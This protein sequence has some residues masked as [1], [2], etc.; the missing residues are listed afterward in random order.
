M[1]TIEIKNDEKSASIT[2]S[3]RFDPIS[4]RNESLRTSFEKM[5]HV[6]EDLQK[7]G[8]SNKVWE[9]ERHPPRESSRQKRRI[10]PPKSQ[11]FSAIIGS[12]NYSSKVKF[13]Q[14]QMLLRR[15]KS[16][17]FFHS[18]DYSP[19]LIGLTDGALET[20][21]LSMSDSGSKKSVSPIASPSTSI[22]GSRSIASS[23]KPK[24]QNRIRIVEATEDSETVSS[25]AGDDNDRKADRSTLTQ[26]NNTPRKISKEDIQE[27]R[28]EEFFLEGNKERDRLEKLKKNRDVVFEKDL[29]GNSVIIAAS[30][31]YL[32]S[33]LISDSIGFESDFVHNLLLAHP[34]FVDT[35]TF[36]DMI[37]KLYHQC[38]E[39]ALSIADD[40]ARHMQT[41]KKSRIINAIRRW[42]SF[43]EIQDDEVVMKKLREFADM[44]ATS[45]DVAE[46]SLAHQLQ[47]ALI[48]ITNESPKLESKFPK[49]KRTSTISSLISKQKKVNFETVSFSDI[50]PKEFAKHMTASDWKLFAKIKNKE[51]LAKAKSKQ[52]GETA[53]PNLLKMIECFNQT[54]NWVATEILLTPNPKQRITVMERFVSLMKNLR[55]YNNFHGTWAIYSAFNK[56]CIQRLKLEWKV[57]NVFSV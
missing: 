57:N 47:Q 21:A 24:A 12:P 3:S 18:W 30:L 34:A 55:N 29:Q 13:S 49:L 36:A 38:T 53:A 17:I 56:S 25:I 15:S 48:T 9:A 4:K 23:T 16:E 42:I 6:I 39:H 50:D 1:E 10:H 45:S 43:N 26:E 52:E 2:T 37:I 33:K 51:F 8:G 40:K 20:T 19:L 14:G 35:A 5:L 27:K 31:D 28:W 54:S 41:I 46:K 44:I 22:P 11:S 32:V 7:S